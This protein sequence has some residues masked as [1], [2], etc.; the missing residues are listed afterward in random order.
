MHLTE[1]SFKKA[2]KRL[3]ADLSIPLAQGQERLASAFNFTNF[4]AALSLLS[5]ATPD[6]LAG[7]PK[8][9]G[10]LWHDTG[11]SYKETLL[12][13]RHLAGLFATDQGWLDKG[14]HALEAGLAVAFVIDAHEGPVTSRRLRKALRLDGMVERLDVYIVEHGE[15]IEDWP[16]AQRKL[17]RYLNRLPAFRIK[18]EKPVVGRTRLRC[19]SMCYE[20]HDYRMTQ[21]DIAL[22][23]MEMVEADV[24]L[25]PAV[26]I[27]AKNSDKGQLREMLSDF[28]TQVEA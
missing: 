3:A 15:E 8:S 19:D 16:R 11:L 25:L 4:D 22:D 28:M 20:Q 14:L 13:T 12:L 21:I 6:T 17:G 27:A 23:I 7:K 10:V 1:A 2:A 26:Q 18:I 5:R 9:T 24:A